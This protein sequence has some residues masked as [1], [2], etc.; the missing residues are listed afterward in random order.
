[1]TSNLLGA[2]NY[3][4]T[5]PRI[6]VVPGGLHLD[7]RKVSAAWGVF[8]EEVASPLLINHQI[9]MYPLDTVIYRILHGDCVQIMP[10]M[11]SESI[12]LILTDPPYLVNYRSRDGRTVR[13]D[14]AFA[15]VAP[16][17][18]EMYRLLRPDTYCISFYGWN[19]VE[20]FITAWK[21]AGFTPVS[22]FVWEK[23]YRS[24]CGFTQSVHE[25]AYLLIKG[26]PPKPE[27]PPRDVWHNW[28]YTGNHLHPTQKPVGIMTALIE[29]YAA[30]GGVVFDPFAGSGTTLVAAHRSGR[31]PVGIEIDPELCRIA[32]QRLATENRKRKAA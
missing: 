23:Q 3:S 8:G 9:S 16:A 15:W 29:H 5:L 6:K 7:T 31:I 13:G 11:P 27:N 22:H 14:T 19:N 18:R 28:Y 21:R 4:A 25:M 2:F 1:M 10:Q 24:K 30:P 26:S 17:F 20:H 12:D 32:T